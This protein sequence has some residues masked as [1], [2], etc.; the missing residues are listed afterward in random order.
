MMDDTVAGRG[1]R[2][3]NPLIED[4]LQAIRALAREFGVARLEVF[5]SACTPDF[6]PDQSDIDFLVEFPADYDFGPWHA[7]FHELQRALAGLLNHHVDLV[8]VWALQNRWFRREAAKTRWVIYDA[9]EVA[10]VA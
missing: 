9:S 3:M 7:R 6:D 10:K 1:E 8:D 5:G 2:H 4:N